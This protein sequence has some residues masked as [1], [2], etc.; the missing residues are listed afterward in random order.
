MAAPHVAQTGVPAPCSLPTS[1]AEPQCGQVNSIRQ[2]CE[3]DACENQEGNS[4][5]DECGMMNDE[6]KESGRFS[7]HSS[8]RIHHFLLS[9]E[10][11]ADAVD[12]D[13]V[14]RVGGYVLDLLPEL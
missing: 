12:G 4:A 9:R 2:E 11:V 6:L 13:D 1:F 8:F 7:F 10:L 5:N 3:R 14:A